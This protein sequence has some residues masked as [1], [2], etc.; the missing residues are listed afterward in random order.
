MLVDEVNLSSEWACFSGV[1]FKGFGLRLTLGT[2]GEGLGEDGGVSFRI[3]EAENIMLL[4]TVD[5]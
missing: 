3:D 5:G 4:E 2:G 1:T